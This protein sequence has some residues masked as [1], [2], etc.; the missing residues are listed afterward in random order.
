[1]NL[2]KKYRNVILPM[3]VVAA[4]LTGVG[5]YFRT[6]AGATTTFPM[7]ANRRVVV[8]DAGHGG[9]DP[10]V[11]GAQGQLEK[12][13][14][15]EIALKLQALLELGGAEVIMTREEDAATGRT[16]SQ[17]MHNRRAIANDSGA[18]IFIS[19]HQNSYHGANVR[20]AQAFYYG[21]SEKGKLLAELIQEQFATFL[22]RDNR[23]PA[24]ANQNYF[25]L[26]QVAIPSVLVETGYL[27]N[28][29]ESRLLTTD[30]YQAKVAWAIY[31]GILNYFASVPSN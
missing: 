23:R 30:E 21:D 26:K 2:L 22:D 6:Q 12:D 27:T 16:K 13:I 20:G 31:M 14:N 9:F 1:M 5:V 8:I 10:G 15:L 11:V 19:I 17:D 18:D 29:N 4:L 28:P 7:P 3:C 24:A 25:V